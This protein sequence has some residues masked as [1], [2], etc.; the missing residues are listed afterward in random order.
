MTANE[1]VFV[2]SGAWIALAV[3]SD[4]YHVRARAAWADLRS[5]GTPLVTSIPV[6]MET[7]TFLDRNTNRAV[8]MAWRDQTTALRQLEIVECRLADLTKSWTWFEQRRLVRL[9]AVDATSFSLMRRLR[10]RSA[11]A[12]DQHFAQAGFRVIG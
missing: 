2:D 1:R 7:F 10:I 3:A 6:V 8:A 12:F 11:F 4:A 9:S 5:A